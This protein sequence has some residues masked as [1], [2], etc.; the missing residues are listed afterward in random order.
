MADDSIPA[1]AEPERAGDAAFVASLRAA[2]LTTAATETLAATTPADHLLDLIVQTATRAIPCPAGTL[3]LVD[4]EQRVLRF[5]V[6]VGEAATTARSLTVPLGRGI[7]GLVAV[8]GQP[9]AIA[10]AQDDPR[11]AREIA[12]RLGYR[13]TTI[14]AVP[15]TA[16]DGAVI[17]VLEL[18]DRQGEKSFSLAD[19]EV[20]GHIA[21]QVSLVIEQRRAQ[22]AL[23]AL[24]GQ[25]LASLGGLPQPVERTIAERAAQFAAAVESDPAMRRTRALAELVVAISRDGPAA[26]S[27]CLGVLEAF[28]AF[29]RSSPAPG[30]EFSPGGLDPWTMR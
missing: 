1:P 13:P 25:T 24:L 22:T 16:A 4:A 2:L 30:A 28:A 5:A 6:V 15:V 14:L 19:L 18:L 11:H 3:F 26:Q 12:E 23:A 7:A 29:I 27:A 9:L 8:S 10:N 20:L 17:G 21:Q